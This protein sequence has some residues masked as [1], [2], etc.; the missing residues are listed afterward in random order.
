MDDLENH[1][2]GLATL[3]APAH[4]SRYDHLLR[5]ARGRE[6]I[7]VRDLGKHGELPFDERYVTLLTEMPYDRIEHRLHE[8]GGD[9]DVCVWTE[10]EAPA[11]VS[12]RDALGEQLGNGLVTYAL[13][14]RAGELAFM[15]RFEYPAVRVLVQRT[16]SGGLPQPQAVA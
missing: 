16:P 3:I 14:I 13:S 11:I 9:G 2:T 6:K 4:Q 15:E 12:L 7:R 1:L 8:L 10:N 5:S